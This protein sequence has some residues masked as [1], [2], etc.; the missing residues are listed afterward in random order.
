[1]DLSIVIL[2]YKTKGLLKQCLKGI[3]AAQPRLE[4]E[5]IVVDNNSGDGSLEMVKEMFLP[6]PP[7]NDLQP[8]LPLI[9]PLALPAIKTIQA[10][11]NGG[12]A[13]GNNLGIKIAAGRYVMILNPDIAVVSEALEKMTAYLDDNPSVGMIGPKLINPD[14]SVQ[15]SCR[16]FPGKFIPFYRRTIFGKLPLTKKALDYYLMNDFDHQT[17][18]EV[19]W[20]FGACLILRKSFL[21]KT[22]LFDE[23]FFMYFEDLDL[24]RRFWEAGFKV[25]YFAD[26]EMVHYHQRLSAEREGILGLFSRGGRIHS[27]SGIKYFAKYLGAKLPPRN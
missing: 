16:R 27:A 26:V 23:R 5:L 22:G 13:F 12:F 3:V 20:L 21:E 2:N 25:A 7:V 17:S 9:K 1:M 11:Y 4:Y 6:P 10:D 15:Y 14:G 8:S 24:G 18:R 19:D